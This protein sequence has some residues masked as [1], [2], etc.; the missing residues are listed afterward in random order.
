MIDFKYLKSI[1]LKFINS[2]M[3]QDH[4]FG[5]LLFVQAKYIYIYPKSLHIYRLRDNS[6]IN[7]H[8]IKKQDIPPYIYN[9]FVS[10]N[11]N[12]YLTREYFS[13][14][15][16]HIILIEC[17]KFLNKYNNEVL[18]SL[19]KKAFF[20]LLI[21]KI[22]RIFNFN[23]DPKNIKKNMK[24]IYRYKHY[25]NNLPIGA[26]YR[27][28]SQLSYKLGQSIMI[29]GKNFFTILLL[30]IIL[31]CIVVSHK[32]EIKYNKKYSKKK[33][34]PLDM[35][36]DYNDALLIKRQM[37]YRMGEIFIKSFKTWYKGG[38]FKL[39]FSIYSLYKEFKKNKVE[40]IRLNNKNYSKC[41]ALY[42]DAGI[43]DY[44]AL[45]PLLKYIRDFYFDYKI[46]F[47]GN[48]RFKD[49]VLT[50]DKDNI[51]EYIYN[52]KNDTYF[53]NFFKYCC[54]DILI[55][56]YYFRS[57][58]LDNKIKQIN[59]MEKIGNYG[60]L[61][62]MTQR[63]RANISVYDKIIYTSENDE[64]EINRNIDFFQK[65]FG[66]K[67]EINDIN[68]QLDVKHFDNIEFNFNN[69]Y[70][71]LFPGAT[72]KNRM[73]DIS[74]FRGVAKHLYD[75][76]KIISYIAGGNGDRHLANDI[77]Q[78]CDF[79]Y[80]ICG[81]YSLKDLFYILN[82]S[83][84]V[85]CNDSGGYHMAQRVSKNIIVVSG[86]GAYTRFVEYPEIFTKDK[87]IS[88]P[89]PNSAKNNPFKEY[90]FDKNL[91]NEISY[92]EICKIIDL[93]HSKGFFE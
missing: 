65:L 54:Y 91:L 52:F 48:N 50:F 56:P 23:K 40:V 31:I 7:M 77:K 49:I 8:N 81:R 28:K 59:A 35:Y 15:S 13:V 14:F 41:L 74:N 88:T 44:L 37:T 3:H 87:L 51:D 10:F 12:M 38:L 11:E 39:P 4:H 76:Y 68:L 64:F 71:I 24:Y 69:K 61:L 63:Q 21:V 42:F 62:V 33:Q 43:G 89:I 27:I 57:V 32:Q 45:Q 75:Q 2:I 84:I 93:K 79:I 73:W 70:A 86:G 47:I 82:K 36:K 9:I 53:S 92:N 85:I 26:T 80:S 72:D 30:P 58:W 20:E 66:K 25:I 46:T 34:L 90:F 6:T 19:F 17:V 67:I 60:G 55:S 1:K 83:Q 29:N 18:N 78:K 22:F 5:M 16:M